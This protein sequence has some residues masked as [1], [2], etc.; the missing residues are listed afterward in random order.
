MPVST[1]VKYF[2]SAMTGAPVLNGTAG[3][4]I[5]V[6]D[7]CLVDGFNLKAVDTLTVAG[8]VATATISTGIGAFEPDVVVLIAGATP[9][10]LNG[11]KR[12]ISATANAV[13]FDA[14]GISDQAAT[15]TITAK[16]A[17]AGWEKQLSG[18]S[19]A[20]YRS[21]DVTSTRAVLRVDDSGTTSARVVGYEGM[22]DINTGTG[23]FPTSAQQSGGLYWP[24]ANA[25]NATARGWTVVAD[26]KTVYVHLHTVTSSI[27]AAGSL[28]AFGD[29]A[30]YKSGDA[31]AAMLSG[32]ASD[33]AASSSGQTADISH[34]DGTRFY[35]PRAYTGLGSSV[36][37]ASTVESYNPSSFSGSSNTTATPAYP[38]GADN[39]LIFSRKIIYEAGSLRGVMRGLFYSV[40][41]TKDAFAW[42][43]K[44]N[45]QGAY[46][47][48][49]LMAIKGAG[50]AGT[51]ALGVTFFDVTG[52][53]V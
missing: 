26:S 10:G 39:A 13:T 37:G 14:T 30:S 4:L 27:G 33:V 52:P 5:A 3:S 25:A 32:F 50:A 6:L 36:V 53:W 19:L 1:S 48:R 23:P 35:V 24:K 44:I 7:A 12:I 41:L 47:G 20:A 34:V 28:V 45:G 11:E 15:G 8:G 51:S 17:A 29:F 18:T 42:R 38:N 31:Y 9:S 21:G 49:K 22:T 40:Q 46:V 2:H 16:L 43:D